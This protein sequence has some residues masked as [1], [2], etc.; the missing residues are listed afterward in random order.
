MRTRRRPLITTLI[1]A[2]IIFGGYYLYSGYLSQEA[3]FQSS[4]KTK[5]ATL[6]RGETVSIPL[7]SFEGDWKIA[8]ILGPYQGGEFQIGKEKAVSTWIHTQANWSLEDMPMAMENEWLIVF[9]FEQ[10]VSAIS[11]SRKHIS[12]KESDRNMKPCWMK[13]EVVREH[14]RIEIDSVLFVFKTGDN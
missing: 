10:L 3:R 6:Q 5:L 9:G 2:G 1:L 8:C 4:V 12:M 14:I 7:A 11:I 13:N